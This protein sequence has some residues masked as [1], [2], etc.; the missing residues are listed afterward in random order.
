MNDYCGEYQT[1]ITQL[2]KASQLRRR[3]V[4]P[5]ATCEICGLEED[6]ATHIMFGCPFAR[7]WWAAISIE[8]P[9]TPCARDLD[10]IGCPQRIPAEHFNR[11]DFGAAA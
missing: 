1:R 9:E 2:L 8:L 3:G 10:A 7:E 11:G 6:T 4:V 5:D